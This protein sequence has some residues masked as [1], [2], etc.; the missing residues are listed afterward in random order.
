MAQ[1]AGKYCKETFIATKGMMIN[2]AILFASASPLEQAIGEY[3]IVFLHFPIV[4]FT[5]AL[6]CDLRSF[7]MRQEDLTWGT[8]FLI[9]GV[10]AC[11]PTIFTGLAAGASLDP[12]PILEKHETLAYTTAISASAY[13]GFRIAAMRWKIAFPI[14]FYVA[15]SVLLVALVSWTADYGGLVVRLK[16]P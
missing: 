15:F 1:E 7:F 9:G 13:A 3:H 6:I 4:L 5:L 12:N 2:P 11:I 14:A 10:I 8:W 16:G